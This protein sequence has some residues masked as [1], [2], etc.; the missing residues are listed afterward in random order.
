[1]KNLVLVFTLVLLFPVLTAA[2][3]NA[4]NFQGRLNDGT[5]PANGLY[6]LQFRL[7]DAA[8]GGAQIG[9]QV[10][11]PRT[12]L[13]NGVFSVALDFGA[14]AFQNPNATFIE[15]AVK[16]NASPN[17]FTILGPRQQLTVVPYASRAQNSTNSDTA[18]NA[19]NLGGTAASEYALKTDSANFIRNSTT[20]QPFS[21]FNISGGGVVGGDFS[22]GG[23]QSLVGNQAIGGRVT[24]NRNQGGLV[25][26]MLFVKGTAAGGAQ[27]VRCHNGVT[28]AST[29]SCGFTVISLPTLNG[30][31]RINFGFQV[32][33]RFV[34][35]TPEYRSSGSIFN[36]YN[37]GVNYAFLVPNTVDVYTFHTDDVEDTT[38][39]DFMI[40]VY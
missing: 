22:I 37:L 8:T 30:V 1:M 40:I 15:I 29:G 38:A 31:F 16:P 27:I 24:Q 17:A 13:I 18:S 14:V 23:N 34:S 12:T 32:D 4:F 28:G 11:R 9:P 21:N 5:S 10:L 25:K 36:K 2:Q 35:L 33:D 7:Y 19:L 6:D 20:P 39:A 26:A 3:G